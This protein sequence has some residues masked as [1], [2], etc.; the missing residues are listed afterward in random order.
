MQEGPRG[1]GVDAQ[2]RQLSHTVE[3]T[4]VINLSAVG[5]HTNAAQGIVANTINL[6]KAPEATHAYVRGG[7]IVLNAGGGSVKVAGDVSA[8]QGRIEVKGRDILIDDARILSGAGTEGRMIHIESEGLLTLSNSK[9][10]ASS[11]LFGGQIRLLGDTV[12][13]SNSTA[14]AN[15]AFGGGDIL[16]GG[17]AYG[18]GPL[19]NAR[20][21]TVDNG[22]SLVANALLNGN[23]GNIVVWSNDATRFSGY[24]SAKGGALGGDGGWIETSGKQFLDVNGI[25]GIDLTAPLGALGTWLLDPTNIYIATN[26]AN[27]NLAGMIG[28]DASANAVSGGTAQASGAVQDSLLTTGVLT[29]ALQTSNVIVTTNNP[30]GTGIGNITIVDPV[31]WNAGTSLTLTAANDIFINAP[32]TMSSTGASLILNATGNVLQTTPGVVGGGGALTKQGAG[33]AQMNAQNTYTGT[34]TISAGTLEAGGVNTLSPVSAV[35]LAGGGTLDLNNYDNRL[36]SLSGGGNVTLG[37]GT[38]TVGNATSTTYS[39]IISGSGGLVKIG[40]GTLSLAGENTYGSTTIMA[41]ILSAGAGGTSGTLG[42]GNVESIATLQLNRSD[43]WTLANNISGTGALTKIATGESTLTGNNTYSGITTISAGTLRAGSTSALSPNSA[44]SLANVSG[45]GLLLDGFN[46]TITSIAGGGTTGGNVD[47][48]SGYL[49]LGGAANTTF[50]G[51]ISGSGGLTKVG[52][53]TFSLTGSNSYTGTTTISAGTISIGTGATLG[54]LGSGN[55]INNAALLINRSDNLTIVND[56]SGTG[57]LTKSGAGIA[58]LTGNNTY[59]GTTSITAGTLQAGI[60][61]AISSNSAMTLSN[62]AGVLLDLNGFNTTIASLAGGGTIGGNVS[63]GSAVL[64]VGNAASTTFS[65]IINGSGDLIKVGTGVLSLAGENTYNTTT[66]SAGTINVGAGSLT[67]TLGSGD[68]FNNAILQFNRTNDFTIANNISGTGS[69]VKS[70]AGTN[71]VVTLTSNNTFSGGTTN[72]EGTLELGS[73]GATGSLGTGSIATTGII[74]FNRSDDFTVAN[75]ISGTGSLQKNLTNTVTLTGANTYSGTTTISGGTLQVGAGGTVGNLGTG[76]VTN[77][78]TLT[79]NRSNAITVANTISGSGGL[80]Q[81]GTGTTTLTANNTYTGATTISAGTLAVGSGGTT[82]AFGSGLVTNNA[83]LLL[84]RSNAV[85]IANGIEGTG[86]LIKAGSGT[87]S[88]TAV[89]TYTGETQVNQGGLTLSGSGTA[90][91]SAF[92]INQGGTLTLDNSGTNVNDRLSNSADLTLSGGQFIIIGNGA[93]NTAE[94]IGALVLNSGYSTTTLTPN[95][96][97]NLAV[98]FASLSRINANGATALFRGTNLGVNTVASQTANSANI[99]FTSAPTLSGSGNAGTNTVGILSGAIGAISSASNGTDFLTYNPPTGS[100]NGLRTLNTATEYSLTPA[101]DVNYRPTASRTANESFAV[102]SILLTGGFTY[103]YGSTSAHTLTIKSGN[104]FSVTG[105]NGLTATNAGSI[106]SFGTNQ[107]HFLVLANTLTMNVSSVTGSGALTKS[108]AGTLLNSRSIGDMGGFFVNSG[109]LN[110]GII[111]S[112][113]S[114]DVTVRSGGIFNLNN[115]NNTM[116]SL[117]LENGGLTGASVTTGTGTLTLT[118]ALTSEVN[119]SGVAGSTITGNLVLPA[120]ASIVV[121][122][123][124][125]ANDL[126]ISAVVSGAGT[127]LTKT[128]AGTLALSGTNTYAG[129]TD[130]STGTLSLGAGAAT[131]TIGAGDIIN[132]GVL[133]INRTGTFTIANTISGTGSL[134]KVASGVASLTGNNTYSGGTT[135]TAGTLSVGAGGT[136]GSIGS[137]DIANAGILQINRSDNIT[138]ANNISG[139]GALIQAGSGITTLSGNNSY[140]GTTTIN[141]GTLRA[142]STSALSSNSAFT[143]ANTSGVV[144]DLNGFSNRIASLTGGGTLGGDVL[145]GS[146]DLTLGGTA[147]TTFSGII[148]GSGGITK[149]GSGT[150]SLAGTNIYNGTTTISAGILSV[151]AGGTSGSLGGGDIVN[152]STLQLNRS[153]DF[154]LAN[155]I[156]GTGVL[157]K[158]LAGIATLSGNST[159]TGS[160]TI[161]AGTLQAGSATAFSSSSA[162]TVSTGAILALNGF[163]NTIAS[164]AGAGDVGLGSNVLT[165]GNASST[166]FSGIIS[167]SGTSGLTKLGIGTLTLTGA[168]TFSGATTVSAGTLSIGAGGVTG[169]LGNGDVI[170]NATLAINRSDAVAL[171]NNISGTGA[172]TKSGAGTLTLSGNNTYSGATTISVGGLEAGSTTALSTNSAFTLANVATAS[173]D[174]NGY[175]NTIASL[176]GGGTLGGNLT[177]GG[178]VLTIGNATST[179]YS[180]AVTEA[181]DIIKQG[182]GALTLAGA[183]TYSGTTTISQGTLNIGAAAA[184]GTLGTGAVINNAT[185]QLNRSDDISLANA[186]SGTGELI[187][188][189]AGTNSTVT[190]TGNNTYTGLTTILEGTLQVGNG[191]T[192]GTIGSWVVSNAGTLSMNRSDNVTLANAV[193]GAGGLT[194]LGTGMTSLTGANAYTGTTTI[195]NGILSVGDGAGIGTL[196]TGSVVNNATLQL[197]RS[198]EMVVSNVISG[199]GNVVKLAAGQVSL[200]GANIYGGTTTISDGILNIG[201]GSTVGA[202]GSGDVINNATLQINRSNAITIANNIS[203]TGALVKLAAGTASL[204]GTNSYSGTTTISAG[205]LSVGA[206]GAT[207]SLGSGD[208]INNAT[209]QLNRTDSF[210]VSNNISGTGALTKIAAGTAILSGSNNYS[211]LTTISAGTLQAGSVSALSA[212]SAVTLANT[213]GALLDLDGFSNTIRSLTGGGT[214]GGNVALGNAILT[215]GDAT[216]TTYSGVISGIGGLTKVGAGALSLAGNNAISG[217]TT[218]S[219]GILNIGAVGTTGLLGTGNVVNNATLQLNRT[220]AFTLVNDISG[221]GNLVK[222]TA[223]ASTVVTLTGNNTYSGTTTIS[224]GTLEIGDGGTSGTLGSGNVLNSGALRFNRSDDHVVGNLISGTG[225]LTQVG[226][227]TISLTAENTYSGITTISQGVLSVGNG[228]TVGQLGTGTVTNNAMLRINRSDDILLANNIAGTG[229]LEQLGAGTLT[230]TGNNTFTGTTSINSG[231]INVTSA[232][233]LGAATGGAVTVNSGTSLTITNVAIGAKNVILN[234]VGSGAGALIGSGNAS[235]DGNITLASNAALAATNAGDVLTLNGQ[236]DGP[237]ALTTQGS[238]QVTFANSLGANSALT[239]VTSNAETLEISGGSILTTGSQTYNSAMNLINPL[240]L[241]AGGPIVAT[242]AVTGDSTLTMNAM[243]GVNLGHSQ[244]SLASI[245]ITNAGGVVSISNQRSAMTILGVAQSG[246]GNTQVVNTGSILVSGPITTQ[247]GN[248][249]LTSNNSNIT[250]NA[251][252][253][254][255]GGAGGILRRTGEVYLNVPP[256]LGQGDITLTAALSPAPTSRTLVFDPLTQQYIAL[257]T[258]GGESQYPFVDE[259][260]CDYDGNLIKLNRDNNNSLKGVTLASLRFPVLNID[261]FAIYGDRGLGSNLSI[262][263]GGSPPGLIDVPEYQTLRPAQLNPAR[264]FPMDYR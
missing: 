12:V 60:L 208:V 21:T 136:S 135:I 261:W 198:N 53:G 87:T 35:V 41:G 54:T 50:L 167:G 65:G 157:T 200:I 114:Q 3:N 254:T 257:I 51:I 102:N 143:L 86:V 159:Y 104:V 27:A 237:F 100:I 72:S 28:A 69:L 235:L 34:T 241:T 10:L 81:I 24:L 253:N 18:I 204:T 218:V 140:T 124:L 260:Q 242:G 154:N 262:G 90:T 183:N 105:N 13:I 201:F 171:A 202:L 259:E 115:F 168:N 67:G 62:I 199:T 20:Y 33:I 246:G 188:T 181:G 158:L 78:A 15:G 109:S 141:A 145:L 238:G 223:G 240:T 194:Q 217:T 236:L 111:N 132:N 133:Q 44:F 42:L 63:L 165:L 213:S 144:L 216:N 177:L 120:L 85:T 61:A 16:V 195:T 190:L 256:V 252:L 251:I 162:L 80:F 174:L 221:T 75:V 249:A 150:F 226:T 95:A 164:L 192:Q 110:S 250:I 206:G 191:G 46:N 2:G 184:T 82:G 31:S 146:G 37:T 1:R 258:L 92:T 189:T 160:T 116:A 96:A 5:V 173:L 227:G 239:S 231:A 244:N 68:V 207:G 123:G 103:N 39:G 56:I 128:D 48:G 107:A 219:D 152:N 17:N 93:T 196:G 47:L 212:N 45:A 26:L 119:G 161:S 43:N 74:R 134:L 229:S 255:S 137:G 186:I 243:G 25:R 147:S 245:Q 209:L 155:N 214:T 11:D 83:T 176:T 122:D 29:T 138:L 180:G 172:L 224:E 220:N 14:E 84:N 222:T 228:G 248:L 127:S 101:N 129:I 148:S 32:I 70:T 9:L 57:T 170:N 73:G 7:T 40:A 59:S 187:K 232:T 225:A 71:T 121:E 79:F 30:S 263:G 169:T 97:S 230:L 91:D 36:A 88:L 203:G 117:T 118:G 210:A 6:S 163:N 94:S 19:K 193:V 112:F 106:L 264:L 113:A 52:S 126:T 156:S 211:G 98:T 179:T 76:T 130:I 142:G 22:S 185:L 125:V 131:G 149:V 66:I 58:T 89:N 77:N 215:V 151:G 175:N 205:T 55:V 166:T 64:T 99:I 182:L 4:G 233:G 139:A 153:N 234:G 23:G 108:G 49:T 247:G 38:L 197:N 8:K 178:G